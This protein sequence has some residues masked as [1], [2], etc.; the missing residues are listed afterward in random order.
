MTDYLH[1]FLYG[2]YPYICLAVLLLGS[3]IRFDRE[4]YTWKSDT[5]Q[6]LRR[7]T[8]RVGSNLFHWGILVVVVG[9]FAGFLAPHWMVSPFLSASGHQLLAMVGGGAAGIVS[10]IGLTM[11]IHRRLSDT[12]VRRNSRTWDIVIVLMLWVQLALGLG[13]VVLSMRH[14]DGALF[15]V[16]TDYVK[17]VV[18]FRPGIARLLDG[19]PLTYQ[20]HI[21]LGFTIFLV[22]PFTRMVHIW[23]GFASLAYL[24]RPYQLVRKR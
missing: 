6:M 9:H 8:L 21:L 1:E 4:Q 12:R 10:I 3:L 19:V 17:G 13:T 15:E 2:I 5:S 18:T 24:I 22:T 11:L 14:M 20:L 7:G 23:S 16:L